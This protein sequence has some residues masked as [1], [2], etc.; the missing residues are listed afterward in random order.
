[1]PYFDRVISGDGHRLHIFYF[2]I[3]RYGDKYLLSE[4]HTY[5]IIRINETS[6]QGTSHHMLTL[7]RNG[8]PKT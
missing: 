3:H 6:K 2:I 8:E 4:G 1:M 5:D 7:L